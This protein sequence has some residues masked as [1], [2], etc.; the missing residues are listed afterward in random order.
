M[1]SSQP[2]ALL[3]I[4]RWLSTPAM[5]REQIE[6]LPEVPFAQWCERHGFRWESCSS[7]LYWTERHYAGARFAES[8]VAP[9]RPELLQ[10]LT[11]GEVGDPKYTLEGWLDAVEANKNAE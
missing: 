5:T 11:P 8:G 4:N 2:D 6:A 1:P 9:L 7:S 3:W 10:C